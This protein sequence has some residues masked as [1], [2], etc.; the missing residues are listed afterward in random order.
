MVCCVA[1]NSGRYDI[2][3]ER[4]L[5]T[6]RTSTSQALVQTG[7]HTDRLLFEYTS[8]SDK[9]HLWFAVVW[10]CEN[11]KNQGVQGEAIEQTTLR[12]TTLLDVKDFV[13]T[14]ISAG[15]WFKTVTL[16][17]PIRQSSF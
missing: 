10:R 15:L 2:K 4:Y 7:F 12:S 6:C 16:V 17:S 11:I 5:C 13:F 1:Y 9:V 8:N 14:V 3:D